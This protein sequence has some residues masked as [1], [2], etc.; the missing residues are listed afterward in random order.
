MVR[1]FLRYWCD[2]FLLTTVSSSALF[3]EKKTA[4][5]FFHGSSGFSLFVKKSYLMFEWSRE[6]KRPKSIHWVTGTLLGGYWRQKRNARPGPH[7]VTQRHHFHSGNKH[8]SLPKIL[9]FFLR[10]FLTSLKKSRWNVFPTDFSP[11]T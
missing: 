5:L 9:F 11:N 7:C 10:K 2:F 6:K 1:R 8:S 3:K 4:C